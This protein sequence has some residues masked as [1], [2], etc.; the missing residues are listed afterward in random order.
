MKKKE[1]AQ[2]EAEN[3][4]E[5]KSDEEENLNFE[6]NL[7]KK[8]QSIW[9]TEPFFEHIF[10]FTIRMDSY[11]KAKSSCGCSGLAHTAH[12]KAHRI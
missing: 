9:R 8:E 1:E 3:Q 10:K 6:S 11:L 5:N 4:Y 12:C 7:G 2:I